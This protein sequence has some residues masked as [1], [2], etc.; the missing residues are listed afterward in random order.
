MS[1]TKASYGSTFFQ[2]PPLWPCTNCHL[3]GPFS[4]FSTPRAHPMPYWPRPMPWMFFHM[5]YNILLAPYNVVI[6]LGG[7]CW[8][9][10]RW[11]NIVLHGKCSRTL[12]DLLLRQFIGRESYVILSRSLSTHETDML[13][14]LTPFKLEWGVVLVIS[15]WFVVLFDPPS[16]GFMI[17]VR[18]DCVLGT[19][20]TWISS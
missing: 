10:F 14:F 2:Y 4:D 16:T 20:Q 6:H 5:L 3:G 12:W 9:N 7:S 11:L 1:V 13:N 8:A 19:L 18:V 15:L 17:Y